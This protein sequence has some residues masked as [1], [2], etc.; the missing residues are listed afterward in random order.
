MK[1]VTHKEMRNEQLHT[2]TKYKTRLS[3]Y[4][5]AL[6][7]MKRYF[8]I[9]NKDRK[10]RRQFDLLHKQEALTR[11]VTPDSLLLSPGSPQSYKRQ[12]Q[13]LT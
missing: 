2:V 1:T 13:Q 9:R 3:D 4:A 10:I 12:E 7:E 8:R 11:P 6:T 5:T